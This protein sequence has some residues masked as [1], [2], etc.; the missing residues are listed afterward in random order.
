MA[1]FVKALR[2]WAHLSSTSAPRKAMHEKK[3]FNC[4]VGFEA[5]SRRVCGGRACGG[6]ASGGGASGSK[7]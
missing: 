1:Q 6:R 2:S 3:A 4:S 5:G 7:C